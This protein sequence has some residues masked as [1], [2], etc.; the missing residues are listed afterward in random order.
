MSQRYEKFHLE[1]FLHR[2]QIR[3]EGARE[4]FYISNFIYSDD[5]VRGLFGQL[6]KLEQDRKIK[7]TRLDKFRAD[8]YRELDLEVESIQ[9][10]PVL[11]W[12][13]DFIFDLPPNCSL[14]SIFV[15]IITPSLLEDIIENVNAKRALIKKKTSNLNVRMLYVA[16]A[17]SIRIQGLQKQPLRNE[18][19]GRPLRE[20][21]KEAKNHFQETF[22]DVPSFGDRLMEG[23]ISLPLFTADFYEEQY[24][25]PK[26]CLSNW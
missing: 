13:I 12:K 18:K 23:L 22:P 1:F 15:E 11:D 3:G 5:Y 14:V 10:R 16:L 26:Y 17:I 4:I 9:Y 24:P 21:Y 6:L 2:D 19:N 8:G 7:K 25:V 20:A